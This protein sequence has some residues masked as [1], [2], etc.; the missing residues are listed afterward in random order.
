ME[1]GPRVSLLKPGKDLALP[2]FYRPISLLDT[3]G[4]VFENIL[5]SRFMAEINY[6]DVLRNEQFR[7]R[8]VNY[9]AAGSIS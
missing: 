4:K 6:R 8:P 7:F 3:V 9:L 1:K 2:T 5:L